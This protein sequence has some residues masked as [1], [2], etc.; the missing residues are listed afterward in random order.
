MEL[1]PERERIFTAYHEAGHL[2]GALVFRTMPR[3]AT[4]RPD[5]EYLGRA[6]VADRRGAAGGLHAEHWAADLEHLGSQARAVELMAG[7]AAEEKAG[8]PDPESYAS[9]DRLKAYALLLDRFGNREVAAR[10]LERA[11]ALARAMM[12]RPEVWSAVALLADALQEHEALF[13]ARWQGIALEAARRI[14]GRHLGKAEMSRWV[15]WNAVAADASSMAAPMAAGATSGGGVLLELLKAVAPAL[16]VFGLLFCAL[17]PLQ[18][19]KEAHDRRQHEERVRAALQEQSPAS[20]AL[21][22]ALAHGLQQSLL[23][24]RLKYHRMALPGAD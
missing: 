8:H 14:H 13:G 18:L 10:E 7:F 6:F 3:G 17:L 11:T 15:G 19:A 2:V 16:A 9:R 1:A 12:R 20:V 22:P 23:L 5:S 24:D 4:I 21:P